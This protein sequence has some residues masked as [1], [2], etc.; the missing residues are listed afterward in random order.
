MEL[1][2]FFFF[3]LVSYDNSYC[4]SVLL[5]YFHLCRFLLMYDE[6]EHLTQIRIDIIA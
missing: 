2:L 4:L 6:I 5:S 1:S 3:L